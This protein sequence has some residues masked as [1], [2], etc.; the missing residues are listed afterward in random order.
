MK[1]A[2]VNNLLGETT[3]DYFYDRTYYP[4]VTRYSVL[5]FIVG[6]CCYLC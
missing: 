2:D 1:R 5:N 3:V 6:V 4:Y